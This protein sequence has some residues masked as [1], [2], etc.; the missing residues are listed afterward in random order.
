MSLGLLTFRS[1]IRSPIIANNSNK[2]LKSLRRH[3]SQEISQKA[4][5]KSNLM[6][7]KEL[8]FPLPYGHL[9]AKEWGNPNGLPVLAVHGW[10]DNSGSFDPL[11]PHI[12]KPHDLHVV[13]ID[14][15]G[16]GLSSH[17][18][19]GSEYGRWHTV[20]EM[21]RVIDHLKW[22]KCTVIGHSQGGHYALLFGASYPDLV[23]RVITIDIFKPLTYRGDKWAKKVSKITEIHMK[24]ENFLNEDPS[25]DSTAPVYSER[26]ALKRMMEAHGNSLNE[27]SARILMKRGTKKQKWGLSFSRDIRLKVP[28]LDPPPTD[29]QMTKFMAH[30]NCDLMIIMAN[31]TPYHIPDDIKHMYYDIYRNHCRYFENVNLDGTHHLHMNDP[32]PVANHI[33]QFISQ[34]L[35][36]QLTPKL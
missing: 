26:D 36:L 29:D 35:A 14:E 4:D 3:Y 17:K 28:S 10:L 27:E 30:L 31:Q 22:K 33:N 12:L 19:P 25:R 32:I 5:N 8:R 20:L 13:A 2:L 7:P 1:F 21:K 34:S 18:P 6:E 23:D 9:A 11:I 15:P 24:Y 16:V